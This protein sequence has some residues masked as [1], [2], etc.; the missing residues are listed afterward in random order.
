M[1]FSYI[2]SQGHLLRIPILLQMVEM[3]YEYQK[4]YYDPSDSSFQSYYSSSNI[5]PVRDFI[6]TILG[7][8][9]EGTEADYENVLAYITRMFYS[10]KG[11]VKVFDYMDRFFPGLR[12]SGDILYDGDTLSLELT[13]DSAIDNTV[14]FRE[15]FIEFLKSLLYL[16][17]SENIVI[18]VPSDDSDIPEV[19]DDPDPYK[20]QSQAQILRLQDLLE[21]QGGG[22]IKTYK[23][24]IIKRDEGSS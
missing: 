6:E 12:R 2:K 5:D 11:T 20:F 9:I 17:G 24:T 16:G 23:L 15:S 13:L 4:N 8:S 1:N 3:Y 19:T 7:S 21:L 14:E 18:I 10:V 22:K